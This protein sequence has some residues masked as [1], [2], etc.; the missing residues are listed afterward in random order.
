MTKREEGKMTKSE[1]GKMTRSDGSHGDAMLSEQ[2]SGV[3]HFRRTT[4]LPIY[5]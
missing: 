2:H 4:M 3:M 5:L 1:E